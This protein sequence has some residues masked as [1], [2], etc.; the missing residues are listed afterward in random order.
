D[1][2]LDVVNSLM[3][4]R[5]LQ[6]CA[7]CA[8]TYSNYQALHSVLRTSPLSFQPPLHLY[9]RVRSAVRTASRA[10]HPHPRG[11]SWRWLGACAA[12][13]LF[14]LALWRLWPIPFGAV[15]DGR[16]TQNLVANHVRSL[17]VSHLTD[18][19]STDRHTVKPWFE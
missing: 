8:Q 9:K 2:E 13:V 11:W 7:L 6:D 1:D 3:V 17:M 16:L 19:T 4:E 18:V 10:D 15:M 14:T 5:H 12:L